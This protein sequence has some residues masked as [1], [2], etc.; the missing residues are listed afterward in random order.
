MTEPNPSNGQTITLRIPISIRKRG[1]RKLVLAPDGTTPNWAAPPQR[2][3]NAMVKAMAR[4][5]RWREMLENGTY[6]TI[7]EIAAAEKINEAYVGRILRLTLLAPEIVNKILD[8][9]Q[10]ASH[11]GGVD[12]AVRRG[13]GRAD[14]QARALVGPNIGFGWPYSTGFRQL[15]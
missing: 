13:V 5:F 6:A 8:G 2:I 9:Q 4:A 1:G 7:A 11:S 12:A 15:T 3:D 14:G 10:P